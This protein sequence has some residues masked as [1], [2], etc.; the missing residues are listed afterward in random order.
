MKFAKKPN[1]LY[2][3]MLAVT[4]ATNR[5]KVIPLKNKLFETLY[6]ALTLL[7]KDPHFAH[8]RTIL[9]DKESALLSGT[10]LKKI[11]FSH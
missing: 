8:V 4:R 1:Q 11:L 9:S 3:F 6:S 7:K 5:V 2:V 10:T